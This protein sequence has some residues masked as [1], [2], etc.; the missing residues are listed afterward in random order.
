MKPNFLYCGDPLRL[1]MIGVT[2]VKYNILVNRNYTVVIGTT[3][4]P[5]SYCLI[6]KESVGSQ[7]VVKLDEIC[8]KCFGQI[9]SIL[10]PSS[11]TVTMKNYPDCPT[12]S[13]M[14]DYPRS[15]PD[16]NANSP[17]DRFYIRFCIADL[18]S[19]DSLCKKTPA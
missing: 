19:P 10:L 16:S 1:L 17:T 3:V 6:I 11:L 8:F 5:A 14:S 4:R 7:M 15:H 9:V 13:D 12:A 2:L 18:R